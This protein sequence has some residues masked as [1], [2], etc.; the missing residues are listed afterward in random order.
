MVNFLPTIRLAKSILKRKFP[1]IDKPLRIQAPQKGPSKNVSPGA[2]FRDFAVCWRYQAFFPGL[3]TC[4]LNK[5]CTTLWTGDLWGATDLAT[6][7]LHLILFSA[8]LR[9]PTFN[10]S[11]LSTQRYCSPNASLDGPF[12]SLFTLFRAYVR[13]IYE[14]TKG[15][16]PWDPHW[17]KEAFKL[18]NARKATPILTCLH[19]A[20]YLCEPWVH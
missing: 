19:R 8:S 9:A 10:T 1:S 20:S 5:R 18:R 2:Y 15:Q 7:S 6:L 4:L 13:I 17:E 16:I 11:T 12:F 3:S 14:K